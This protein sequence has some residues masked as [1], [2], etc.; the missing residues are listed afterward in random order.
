MVNMYL[1]CGS[2]C[3]PFLP[4]FTVTVNVVATNDVP[5]ANDD[6]TS[7]VEDTPVTVSVLSNDS[8]PDGH[9]LSILAIITDPSNGDVIVNPDGT[10]K[11]TPDSN[12]FGQDTFVYKISD[13]NGGTDTATGKD[14]FTKS[15]TAVHLTELH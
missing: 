2:N 4:P 1:F 13:G 7:T 8:D 15:K 3:F 6:S 14:I 12:F 10:I 5:V 11:Y 9:A